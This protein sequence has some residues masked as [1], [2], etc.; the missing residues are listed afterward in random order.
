MID[1]K[2]LRIGNIVNTSR[3]IATVSSVYRWAPKEYQ[4]AVNVPPL[5]RYEY[6]EVEAEGIPLT[7]EIFDK[8]AFAY[9][10]TIGWVIG[11]FDIKIINWI[12][13][14]VRLHF[15]ISGPF[16]VA[17]NIQYLHQLQNLYFALTNTEL[18]VN[19]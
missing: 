15:G 17:K 4:I 12:D 11:L 3:G 6:Q 14:E 13:G 16:T 10:K 8:T 1:P 2:E 7:P 9:D 5:Q 19:L 18:T